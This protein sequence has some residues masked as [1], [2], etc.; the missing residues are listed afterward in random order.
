MQRWSS[1][2]EQIGDIQI[3]SR[4]GNPEQAHRPEGVYP[5]QFY[6]EPFES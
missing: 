3:D 5:R 2:T 1:P 4:K 6:Q